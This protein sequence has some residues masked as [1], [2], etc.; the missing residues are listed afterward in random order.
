MSP[1]LRASARAAQVCAHLGVGLLMALR[2]AFD[3]QQ[4]LQPAQLA[5]RWHARLLR[6]LHVSV[7]THGAALTGAQLQVANHVSWLDIPVL[8]AQAPTRFIAKSEIRRWPIAGQ[9]AVACGTLF[10]RRGQHGARPLLAQLLPA[11]QNGHAVTLFPEGTTTDGRTLK[12]FH[13]RLFAAAVEAPCAVQPLALRYLPNASGADVAPFIGDDDLVRHLWRVLREPE[14]RVVVRYGA[15][16]CDHRDRSQLAAA[17]QDAVSEL[18]N[19][20]NAPAEAERRRGSKRRP[21]PP[22]LRSKAA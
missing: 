12:P 16:L 6:I 18:L 13:A 9:L 3:R 1:N 14:L 8:A 11:L 21:A 10:I 17:A 2:V 20:E 19:T 5:Q 22:R 4:R 7:E 15:P